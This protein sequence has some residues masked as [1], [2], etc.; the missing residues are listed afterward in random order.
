MEKILEQEILKVKSAMWGRGYSNGVETS[1]I[2]AW[3]PATVLLLDHVQR[4]GPRRGRTADKLCLSR[5]KFFR[6]QASRFGENRRSGLSKEQVV[7]RRSRES[8]R[9]E[10][11]GKL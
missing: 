1:I 4:R 9:G 3:S 8:I 6:I 10:N 5:G 2:S 7:R 11:V